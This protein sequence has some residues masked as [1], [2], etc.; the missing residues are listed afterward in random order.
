MILM[1]GP[2]K[3]VRGL[4][5]AFHIAWGRMPQCVWNTTRGKSPYILDW[6][7]ITNISYVVQ[8]LKRYCFTN[9][10]QPENQIDIN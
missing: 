4:P 10:F 6:T 5:P 8:I 1:P 2:S 9:V 7:W 3:G